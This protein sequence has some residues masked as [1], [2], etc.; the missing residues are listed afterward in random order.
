MSYI[1]TFA[2]L[3]SR[4]RSGSGAHGMR[5]GAGAGSGSSM[6]GIKKAGA[7]GLER[8]ETGMRSAYGSGSGSEVSGMKLI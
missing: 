7:V 4:I 8:D 1:L 3:G 2:I 6:A 5:G